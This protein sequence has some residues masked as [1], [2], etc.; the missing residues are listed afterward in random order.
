MATTQRKDA[1]AVW[2]TW[3]TSL[4][5]G[6]SCI[7]KTWFA[8]RFWFK[9]RPRPFDRAAWTADHAAMVRAR[10]EQL[11]AQGWTVTVEDQNKFSVRVS[12]VTVAGQPDI[13]AVKLFDAL[14]VDCKTGKQRDSDFWQ[15]LIYL[16]LL[17]LARPDRVGTRLRGEVQYR[18]RSLPIAPEEL[19]AERRADVGKLLATIASTDPPPRAPSVRECD[20]CDLSAVDCPDRIEAEAAPVASVDAF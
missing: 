8:A 11:R 2:V 17:P 6:D 14:V 4:L 10:V 16:R 3:L 7:W 19:N 15:V 12:G 18:D 1:P 13:V 5:A 9:K 20:F